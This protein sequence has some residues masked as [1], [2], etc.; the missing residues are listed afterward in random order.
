MITLKFKRLSKKIIPSPEEITTPS[1]EIQ[2]EKQEIKEENQNEQQIIEQEEKKPENENIQQNSLIQEI[3]S[4][5]TNIINNEVEK[6]DEPVIE[7]E[8]KI[9]QIE[10]KVEETNNEVSNDIN[11]NRP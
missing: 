10:I 4:S 1:S 5:D 3:V 8:K 2:V 6:K 7:D 11:T 9:K